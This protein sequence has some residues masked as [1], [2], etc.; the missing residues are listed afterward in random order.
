MWDVL[1]AVDAS[2][3][4]GEEGRAPSGGSYVKIRAVK[5][6][7]QQVVKGFPLPYGSR[8]GVMGFRAPTKARG[9]MLDTS[10][11]RSQKVL[12][13]T[14][15]SELLAR[16]DFLRDSLDSM[17]VGGATPTGEGLRAAVDMLYEVS[18]GPRRRIKKVVLVTDDKSNVGPKPDDVLDQKLMRRVILDVVAIGKVNDRKVFEKLASRSGGKL[19]MVTKATDLALALDPRIPYTDIG[20]PSPLLAEA[21]RI[22]AVLNATEKSAPSYDGLVAAAAAVRA[23][24]GAKVQETVSLEGQARGDFDLVLSAAMN[25]PKWPVMSMKEFADRV[26]SRGA[27]LSRLQTV[28]ERFRTAMGLL[29]S[30]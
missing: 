1:Y 7:I 24:L 15:V 29:P 26:W 8:V 12:P 5:E 10:K 30:Q 4:M 28:E 22:A 18:D 27:E 20:A 6:G 14:S 19:S 17:V 11:G 2:T 23:K 25:D 13:L 21:E 3:S 16:P 9:M